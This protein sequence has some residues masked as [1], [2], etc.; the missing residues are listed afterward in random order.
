M[1]IIF[2]RQC[3]YA[4][5]AVLFMAC[6]PADSTTSIRE[7]TDRLHTPYFFMAKI[8]QNLSHKGLLTSHK[9]PSG[10]FALGRSVEEITLFDVVDAIDGDGILH[11]CVMGFPACTPEQTCALHEQWA[12]SREAINEVL[13]KRTIAQMAAAMHKEEYDQKLQPIGHDIIG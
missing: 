6:K 4:L 8:L 11:D 12:A 5:Q 13:M 2:S 9:G 1:S 3:E 7:L 10:G